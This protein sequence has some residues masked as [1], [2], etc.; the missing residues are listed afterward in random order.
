MTWG[1]RVP[2][3]YWRESQFLRPNVF[4]WRVKRL[5]LECNIAAFNMLRPRLVAPSTKSWLNP[6][7]N[8]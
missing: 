6:L 3:A 2:P 8:I 7:S 1:P 4:I 5:K